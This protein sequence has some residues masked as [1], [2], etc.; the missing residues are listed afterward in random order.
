MKESLRYTMKSL[1]EEERPRE[2][3]YKYGVKSLSNPELLSII[4]RTGSKEYSAIELSNRLLSIDKQGISFLSDSSIEEI[5]KVK[6][7]G[8]C[9]A[10]QILAAIELGKRVLISSSID[11]KKITSPLDVV[12]FL[13]TDMQHLKKEYFKV[14]MLDTKNK[15]IGI[16]DVSVG[17]LNSSIVHPRE[18]FKEAVKRSSASMI[19]THNHPS[20]DPSPSKE[21]INVTKRLLECGQILGIS[22]LDHIVIGKNTYFSFRE[23]NIL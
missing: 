18:V 16:D 15:I 6:G 22:I 5:T 1:P 4:I 13:I 9:K 3:L 7:I 21:D 12:N 19:L 11:Q 17:S 14:I 20:G 23:E 2:K 10:A 8:K